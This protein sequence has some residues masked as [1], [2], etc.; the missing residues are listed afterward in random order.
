MAVIM[1]YSVFIHVPKTGGSWCRAAFKLA[2]IPHFESGPK[3]VRVY[4]HRTHASILDALDTITVKDWRKD[5]TPM[6]RYIFGF[7]R[8]PLRWLE[9]RWADSVRKYGAPSPNEPTTWFPKVFSLR[10]EEFI[11]N[12]VHQCPGAPSLAMLGRLGF[13]K[14]GDKWCPDER[15]AD[16]IGKQE[17]L[18]SD[19][20]T[21]L[22]NAGETFPEG[23]FK[24]L[25]PQRVASRL[26][27]F[28]RQ[29]SWTPEQQR[30]IYEA[31]KQLCEMYDY[32]I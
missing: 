6:W 2:K 12:V 13:H 14:E 20:V 16:F 31:N 17:N 30:V 15:T 27:K 7:V 9:S 26:D 24:R 5:S 23:P 29:I 25:A 18:R 22:R 4:T 3:K 11:D 21:A 32:K 19:V 8:H 28:K 10:F 1:P